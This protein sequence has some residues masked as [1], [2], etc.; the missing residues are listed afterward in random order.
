[1]STPERDWELWEAAWRTAGERV[2]PAPLRRLLAVQRRR[3]VAVAAG[4]ALVV[5]G[6]VVLTWW[7]ASDGLEAWEAVWLLTLWGFAA[8]A[9]GFAVWNRRGTWRSLGEAVQDHVRLARQRAA[10]NA[11]AS[12]FACGLLVAETV[13]VLAQLA[14]FGRLTPAAVACLAATGAG[15]GALGFI[16]YRRS[17]REEELLASYPPSSEPD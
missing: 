12:A 4:E 16:A 11:R 8:V 17:R 9:T 15:I 14:W 10:R 1:M 2:D 3:L 6:C 7:I 13:A 5:A